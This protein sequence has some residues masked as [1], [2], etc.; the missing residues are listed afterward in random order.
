MGNKQA[1]QKLKAGFAKVGEKFESVFD[2]VMTGETDYEKKQRLA[3]E[4]KA[5]A[6]MMQYITI[7]AVVAVAGLAA[8]IIIKKT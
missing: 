5:S 6:D 7:G 8:F 4:E 2:K 1:G 3:E